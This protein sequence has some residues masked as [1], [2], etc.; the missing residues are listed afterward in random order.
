[1]SYTPRIVAVV[2]LIV[3]GLRV[4]APVTATGAGAGFTDGCRGA[5]VLLTGCAYRLRALA[6][7]LADVPSAAAAG[8]GG[9]LFSR[10]RGHEHLQNSKYPIVIH[11]DHRGVNGQ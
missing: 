11:R 9:R 7:L 5:D 6:S 3:R 8:W 10:S 2:C 1:M 4:F